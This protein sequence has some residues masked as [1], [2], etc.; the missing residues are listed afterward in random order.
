[1]NLTCYISIIQRIKCYSMKRDELAEKDL[2]Y[3]FRFNPLM[4][5]IPIIQNL[6]IS[7]M[8]KVLSTEVIIQYFNCAHPFKYLKTK[9]L[10]ARANNGFVP[11]QWPYFCI[12]PSIYQN[13]I[14]SVNRLLN[15]LRPLP[16]GTVLYALGPIIFSG[17]AAFFKFTAK[18]GHQSLSFSNTNFAKGE[19][20]SELPRVLPACLSFTVTNMN[21]IEIIFHFIYALFW[22]E[23]TG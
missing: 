20:F 19:L 10:W 1:M 6:H 11:T 23:K 13:K 22:L 7:I 17:E 9:F 4:L 15:Q 8:V 16:L 18:V 2:N 5:V 12:I 14:Y 3:F 21:G